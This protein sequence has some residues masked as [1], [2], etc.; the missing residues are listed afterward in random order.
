MLNKSF[1]TV[2]VPV[3]LLLL[4][5]I[6]TFYTA[7]NI[8]NFIKNGSEQEALLSAQRT[9][10]Q[11]KTLRSYYTENVIKKILN[12]SELHVSHDHK[13]KADTV[14]LPVTMIHDLSYL[15]E[16]DGVALK[17]YS[18]YPFPNRASRKMD[19]FGEQAWKQILSEPDKPFSRTE[20]INGITQVRVAIA[21]KMVDEACVNC[22]NSH[23]DTPKNDWKRGDV[24][25]ILEVNIPIN[26]QLG[27]A[28]ILSVELMS[29]EFIILICIGLYFVYYKIPRK[30]QK[31]LLNEINKQNTQLE[32][33]I[34]NTDIGMCDWHLTTNEI[35]FNQSWAELLGYNHGELIIDDFREWM[36]SN[37]HPDDLIESTQLLIEYLQGKSKHYVCELRTRHKQGH[38]VWLL[39]TFK[40]IEW[41]SN[42]KPKRM[43]GTSLDFTPQKNV[44]EKLSSQKEYYET[45]IDY[46]NF[47][48]FIIDTDHKVVTWNK[49]CESLTGVNANEV[50]GTNEHWRVFYNSQRACLADYVLD[51]DYLPNSKFHEELSTLPSSPKGKRTQNWYN[52]IPSGKELFLDIDASPIFDE[53]G[54]IIA[55]IEV[56][57]DITERKQVKDKLQKLS[58]ALEFSS[59]MVVITD[60][61]GN[62]EYIN[63]QFTE[64]TGYE[65]EEVLGKNIDILNSENTREDIYAD[66]W[67]TVTSGR[68]WKK[69]FLNRKK[70]G[71]LFWDHTSISC[72]KDET[73]D[74]TNYICIQE[75]VTKRKQAEQDL[76]EAKEEAEDATLAKS[77]F[78]ANMSHEIR[79]PMNGILGM[80]QILLDTDLDHEQRDYVETIQFS[81]DAL[82][83]IINDI[84]DFSKIESGKLKFE[85]VPFDLQATVIEVTELLNTKCAQKNIELILH[86]AP[87]APRHFFADPGRL[88]QILLNLAGNSIKFT[89]QGHVLIEVE[90]LQ[91]D[92]NEAEIRFS[93]EDTGIGIGIAKKSQESLFDSFSQADA[94][95]TRKYGGTGLG[96]TICKQL[97]ELMGGHIN[98]E[99]TLGK[100]S[101]FSFSVKLPLNNDTNIKR[102]PHIELSDMRVLVVD[103]NQ[104]NCKILCTYLNNWKAQVES[105]NSGKMALEKMNAA[106]TAEKPY[107]LAILDYQMPEMDGAQLCKTIKNNP[108]L[109]NTQLALLSSSPQKDDTKRFNAIGFSAYM[110]K[111]FEPDI[112]KNMLLV[113]WD[114]IQKK[115]NHM[116]ILTRYSII[117]ARDID[118]KSHEDES[119]ENP[120]RVLVVEDNIVN[121]KVAKKLLEKNGC[122]VD[123]ASN[124][125]EGV[126]KQKLFSYDI[127]FMDCQMPIMDGFEATESIRKS[128]EGAGKH[129]VIIAMTANVIEG[130]R[131]NCINR[132]MDDYL[133]KPININK[134]QAMLKKWHHLSVKKNNKDIALKVYARN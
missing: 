47:P 52:I 100:G 107:H 4:L 60:L 132:G 127:I 82:L 42:G 98:V 128:E 13:N 16:K 110:V 123:I 115:K 23:S 21:D 78:L 53:E 116:P 68:I 94:S 105:V 65:K 55:V 59:T 111:P 5:F 112:L 7:W 19:D 28:Q 133:S 114:N 99:S 124:G 71:T 46:F 12:S 130:D 34:E 57:K 9:V 20:T 45:I 102:L 131:E 121:Q 119:N 64:I 17:L 84:L 91:Q 129:Q 101:T 134:L 108:L 39:N 22:H 69:E 92:N 86:Y 72:V 83:S 63:S 8:L 24:F 51:K 6:S 18:K 41:N 61:E 106:V 109:K 44:E 126:E 37:C 89:E 79:T 74:I 14:P 40:I 11:F 49:S 48:I 32:L 76:R 97:T 96:L 120:M 10:N 104:I 85:P 125:Q 80:G 103:D 118:N 25:G 70:D 29:I 87:N 117:E 50:I 15:M 1:L 66:L 67:S 58:R 43:V 95:T 113:L 62:I 93:V 90:C 122:V 38:W 54:N 81:S 33:V 88:R 75:D 35:T 30:K 36:K 2:I 31:E 56:L 73:G 26:K 77:E 3:L 27:M